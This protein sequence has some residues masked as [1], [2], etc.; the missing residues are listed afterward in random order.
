MGIF[1]YFT[2]TSTDLLGPGGR[3][4]GGRRHIQ[5]SIRR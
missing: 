1:F 3:E 4:G 2:Q 5:D